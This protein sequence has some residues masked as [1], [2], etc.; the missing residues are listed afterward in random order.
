MTDLFDITLL[1]IGVPALMSGLLYVLAAIDPTTGQ[2]PAD[3]LIHR[4]SA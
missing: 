3:D 4:S 2:V 1:V